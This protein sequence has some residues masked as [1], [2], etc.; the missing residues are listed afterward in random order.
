ML[1]RM[2][3]R[4]TTTRSTSDGQ[5]YFSYRLVESTRVAG[6]VKQK[7][8]LNLGR[9]FAIEQCRWAELCSRVEQLL[10]S[11][12]ELVTSL[13]P[14][15]IEQEAQHIFAR[16]LSARVQPDSAKTDGYYQ[17]IQSLDVSS[18]ELIQPRSVGVE[19]L[20]LWAINEL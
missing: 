7:T 20:S 8:L 10:S 1:S 2:Y 15:E 18:L 19:H 5:S 3:I 17:D 11:Q 6:K 4:R 14:P 12:T 13:L 16:L 9:H